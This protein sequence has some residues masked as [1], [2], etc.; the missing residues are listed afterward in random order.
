MSQNILRPFVTLFVAA[1]Y[2]LSLAN[3]EVILGVSESDIKDRLNYPKERE[4]GLGRE[5]RY[6]ITLG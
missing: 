4:C 6:N 1:I 5:E 3:I 2:A